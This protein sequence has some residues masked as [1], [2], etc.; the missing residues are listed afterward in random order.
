MPCADFRF[1]KAKYSRG[2]QPQM[3]KCA[4]TRTEQEPAAKPREDFSHVK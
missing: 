4:H 2:L 1:A 3:S